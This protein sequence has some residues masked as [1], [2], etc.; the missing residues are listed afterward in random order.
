MSFAS[1]SSGHQC[2]QWIGMQNLQEFY[3]SFIVRTMVK[4]M[5]SRWGFSQENPS[6]GALLGR[7]SAPKKASGWRTPAAKLLNPGWFLLGSFDWIM[8]LP[9]IYWVGLMHYKYYNHQPTEVLNT[10]HMISELLFQTKCTNCQITNVCTDQSINGFGGLF[11][12]WRM[13]MFN[14][15]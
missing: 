4:T 5:V 6:I 3:Q 7:P 9:P 10:A 11:L 8:N 15:V 14:H 13:T 1:F 2:H 12:K